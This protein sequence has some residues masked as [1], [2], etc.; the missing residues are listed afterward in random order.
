MAN[1]NQG[2]IFFQRLS[3]ITST[4]SSSQK[5]QKIWPCLSCWETFL[6]PHTIGRKTFYFLPTKRGEE[7]VM[8]AL[9]GREILLRFPF[10]REASCYA[11]PSIGRKE[12]S[13]SLHRSETYCFCLVS[14]IFFSKYKH[15]AIS[16]FSGPTDLK[17]WFHTTF[18]YH[19]LKSFRGCHGVQVNQP[20][21][22]SLSPG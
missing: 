15:N 19:S 22:P 2:Q 16:S 17:P 7:M 6:W 9:L 3:N 4:S 8:S 5:G 18:N 20:C 14:L 10:V 11:S 21:F 1:I 12:T 13:L